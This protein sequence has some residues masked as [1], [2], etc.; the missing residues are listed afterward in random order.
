MMS[1]D[2][3][4]THKR[5]K[6]LLQQSDRKT[7]LPAVGHEDQLLRVCGRVWTAHSGEEGSVQIIRQV[8]SVV[9]KETRRHETPS[10]MSPGGAV[11]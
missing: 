11:S 10:S 9:F 6:P 7:C 1:F 2:S 8:H 5:R 3:K 4:K